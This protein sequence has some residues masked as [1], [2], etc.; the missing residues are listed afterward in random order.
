[1]GDQD[2][3]KG[4]AD[5]LS[6]DVPPSCLQDSAAA[7][8]CVCAAGYSGNGTYCSGPATLLPQ[9]PLEFGGGFPHRALPTP[10]RSSLYPCRFPFLPRPPRL[11]PL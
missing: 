3:G 10:S 8:A 9:A 4:W 6:H 11:A 5:R 2:G 7:P 1:M